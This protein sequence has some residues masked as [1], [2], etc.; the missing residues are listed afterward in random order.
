MGEIP[1]SALNAI[2]QAIRRS[3]SDRRIGELDQENL[4]KWTAEIAIGA[5]RTLPTPGRL[6]FAAYLAGP[7]HVVVPKEPAKKPLRFKCSVGGQ[8]VSERCLSGSAGYPPCAC[9][10][11]PAAQR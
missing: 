7:D 11:Y 4:G 5:L 8:F 3:N 1:E 6:A 10:R 2:A 9:P